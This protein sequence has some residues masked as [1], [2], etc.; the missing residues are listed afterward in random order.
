MRNCFVIIVFAFNFIF[1]LSNTFGQETITDRDGYKYPTVK[2]GNQLWMAK[3]LETKHYPDGTK[4]TSFCYN[5]DSVYCDIYGRLYPW[6]SLV[7]GVNGDSLL[8]VCPYGWHLP[9]DQEWKFLIDTLGGPVDAGIKL[10]KSKK[11]NLCFQ[12]GGNYQTELDVFSF[13]DRKTY[14]WSSTKFS[15][16]AAWMIMTGTNTKNINRSTVPKEFSFSV[17]CV[18]NL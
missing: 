3:N 14:L 9:S 13:I 5:Y 4:I 12:W 11:S 2:I 6:E 15:K 7:G 16:T 18:K 10:K 17:R 8:N 1:H